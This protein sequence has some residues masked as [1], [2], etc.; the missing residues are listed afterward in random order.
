VTPSPTISP[1][2]T[3][4]LQITGATPGC[5][6]RSGCWQIAE[7][8]GRT[9]AGTLEQQLEKQGFVL[10]RQELEPDT[11]FRVYLVAKEGMQS[12][13]LHMIWSDRGTAYI[14]DENLLSYDQITAIAQ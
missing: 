6:G 12:Y 1:S 9:V 8:N 14:R 3:D 7:S 2:P 13:Y 5:Q 10:T 11:G 4:V